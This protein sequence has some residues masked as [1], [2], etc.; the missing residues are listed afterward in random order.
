M[1]KA[2]KSEN[3]LIFTKENANELNF[4]NLNNSSIEVLTIASHGIVSGGLNGLT[5]SALLMSPPKTFDS[6]DG[7][8][9]AD[10]IAMTNINIKLVILSACNTATKEDKNSFKSLPMSFFY[11]GA[12]N[13]LVS[14]WPVETQSTLKITSE[15]INNYS[16]SSKSIAMDLR[17]SLLKLK[18]QKEYSHP[19]FWGAFSLFGD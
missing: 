8:L 12:Q 6:D 1:N 4:K 9:K 3:N 10:E 11:S 14:G 7:L 2:Q 17:E 16:T 19:V 15:L 13:I 5:E 18:Q